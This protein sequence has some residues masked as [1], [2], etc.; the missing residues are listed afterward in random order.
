MNIIKD[1]ADSRMMHITVI[2]NTINKCFDSNQP[3]NYEELLGV[4]CNDFRTTRRTAIEYIKTAL[5]EVDYDIRPV[6]GV[7][8]MKGK[9]VQKLFKLGNKPE[10]LKLV[11]IS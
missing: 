8:V 9:K 5:I 7:G 2:R 1:Q 3:I 10:Q 6:E 4:I 11:K